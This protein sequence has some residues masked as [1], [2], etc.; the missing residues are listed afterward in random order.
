MADDDGVSRQKGE[1]VEVP[2]EPNGRIEKEHHYFCK[3]SN[4][5]GNKQVM[6]ADTNMEGQ[7]A[8]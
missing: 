6:E 8:S 5:A 1:A 2:E 7:I 3:P 4:S